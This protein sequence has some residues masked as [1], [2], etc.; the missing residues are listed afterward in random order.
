M[1]EKMTVSRDDSIYEAFP[2][3]ALTAS[4]KLV[5]VFAE[6]THHADRGYTRIVYTTSADRG[7]TW[8]PKR[9]LSCELRGQSRQDPFWNCPRITALTDGRLLAVVDRVADA[10]GGE[11]ELRAEQSNWLWFSDDEADT[12]DGPHATPVEGIVPDQ[13]VE[14]KHGP[15]AGRWLLDA[16]AVLPGDSG[17]TWDVRC[18]MSDDRGATWWG[19]RTVASAPGL[20]LCEGSILE[21]PGGELVCFMRE[22]SFRGLDCFKAISRDGGETWEEPVAMPIPACHR[23]VAGMLNSGRVMITHRFMQGGKGWVGW[24]TQNLFAALTDVES[25]L[26]PSR[27]EAHTRIMPLDFDRSPES[28][29]GYSGWVQSPDGGIFVVTYIM[30]DAP[31]AQIRGYAFREEDFVLGQ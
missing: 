5:C 8:A 14:L 3:V 24:W 31:K 15:H 13:L 26:A 4:G 1:I 27:G 30:D 18:W 25:C 19:P 7:R 28:D 17:P 16:H 2:D 12:W 9:P 29:T 6:C 10:P 23:P 21:L 22:N 20:Q 11:R